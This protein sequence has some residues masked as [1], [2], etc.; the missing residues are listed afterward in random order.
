MECQVE[1]L[2]HVHGTGEH[3]RSIVL[4]PADGLQHSPGAHGRRAASLVGKLEVIQA[5]LDTKQDNENSVNKFQNEAADSYTTIDLTAGD[6]SK[7][8]LDN[9]YQGG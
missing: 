3:L 4:I 2:C 1:S 8:I 9:W 7:F 5:E 6:A